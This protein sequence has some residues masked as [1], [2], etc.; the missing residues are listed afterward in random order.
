M[1][2]KRERKREMKVY[3]HVERNEMRKR[4]CFLY[5]FLKTKHKKISQ[6][7]FCI[8]KKEDKTLTLQCHHCHSDPMVVW[9]TLRVRSPV[10]LL[11]A[12]SL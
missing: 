4:K 1:M 5:Y 7:N 11:A 12:V 2:E 8:R 9:R 3:I 10:L 6:T